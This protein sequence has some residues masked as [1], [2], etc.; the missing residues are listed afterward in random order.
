[1]PL[2]DYVNFNPAPEATGGDTS[3]ISGGYYDPQALAALGPANAYS[4]YNAANTVGITPFEAGQMYQNAFNP[5][6]VF[7]G[8]AGVE[9]NP[10]LG[11][12]LQQTS[13]S[14]SGL[15]SNIFQ[16]PLP[17]IGGAGINA[18]YNLGTAGYNYLTGQ[19]N[20]PLSSMTGG[21]LGLSGGD[22]A[23]SQQGIPSNLSLATGTISPVNPAA[24]AQQQAANLAANQ[25]LGTPSWAPGGIS[26]EAL[27]GS[28]GLGEGLDTSTT[29]GLTSP[30]ASLGNMGAVGSTRGNVSLG[31][32]QGVVGLD[33]YLVGG[34]QFIGGP[35]SLGGTASLGLTPG[36]IDLGISNIGASTAN[37]AI[38]TGINT[39]SAFP[40]TASTTQATSS[41]LPSTTFASSN[42]NTVNTG[43]P[44]VMPTF[45]ETAQRSQTSATT[46]IFS[47][48][49]TQSQTANTG[50]PVVLPTFTVSDQRT[51]SSS[52]G[53]PS[54]TYTQSVNFTSNTVQPTST[55]SAT[56]STATQTTVTNTGSMPTNT[57]DTSTGITYNPGAG[58][59]AGGTTQ[60]DLAAELAKT[61]PALYGQYNIGGQQGTIMD[62]YMRMY[63]GL[64]GQ[65]MLGN[66]LT[67][68]GARPGL[69]SQIAQQL[70][71][72][73]AKL[74]RIQSGQ[75]A[76]E[77]VRNAT[78]QAREAYGA[79][80][81]VMGPG[82]IGAE[83]LNREAIRQQRENEARAAYQA[84]MQNA[85]NATQ[86]QT[87][88]IFSPIGQLVS[89]TF[90]PLG[91]YPQDV[92]SSNVNAQLA[93]D[94]AAAN[95]A[96]A[97]EAAK[98]GAAA[99]QKAATTGGIFDVLAKVLPTV[100]PKI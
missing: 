90:N 62:Q 26:T 76:A 94:I 4:Y 8:S 61:I 60:R 73:Q 67:G 33:P 27:A 45:T 12:I 50:G 74:Q 29:V 41:S 51:Q 100:I 43:A 14:T 97:I 32:D 56:T 92:Y 91:A 19:G 52:T 84:S 49:Y 35:A 96:A 95:N 13:P 79:R 66:N 46:N 34:T 3:V 40:V 23:L 1:M 28:R 9:T 24:Y 39:M 68:E 69:T 25:Y 58:Q 71:A 18:L 57:F 48:T 5:Q 75:L 85:F 63:Q 86:L 54:S 6:N 2:S 11:A 55:F 81:Q 72:D 21:N 7:T 70:A 78:Q 93:R 20:M 30:E 44:V 65:T 80:G 99:S 16:G 87:G 31:L 89:G 59:V 17:T 42:V 77:D 82:A 22:L 37:Q 36:R 38:N 88:N 64:L 53:I 10:F 98:Y 15:P 83:I 47:S